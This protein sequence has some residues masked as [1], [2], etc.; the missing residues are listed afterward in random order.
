MTVL[1]V[2]NYKD[3]IEIATDSGVFYGESGFKENNSIKIIEVNKI[4]FSST[5]FVSE[6]NFLELYCSTR[7]PESNKKLDIL[8]FFSNFRKWQISEFSVN[9]EK[10][11][12]IKNNFFFYF[13]GKIYK[14]TSN[15]TIEEIKEG[16]FDSGGA[17]YR[18]AKTALYLGKTPREAVEVTLKVN[19]WT[20]GKVQEKI[21]YKN[22]K[23]KK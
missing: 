16:E 2:K 7:T 13:N 20:S 15:L 8:R 14:I 12:I 22:N 11:E 9:F 1:A 21:I 4:I 17:G 19:A 3:R 5:G 23:E 10:T 6:K 18:E